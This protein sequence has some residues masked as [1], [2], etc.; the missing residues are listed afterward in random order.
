MEGSTGLWGD[1]FGGDGAGAG[2]AGAA[3]AAACMARGAGAASAAACCGI[4]GAAAAG[5]D[6]GGA[7]IF[8]LGA[9]VGLGG[10]VMRTVSFLGWTFEASAGFGGTAPGAGVGVFSDIGRSLAYEE[11]GMCQWVNP[12]GDLLAKENAATGRAR[13]PV[14]SLH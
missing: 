7:G 1:A 12:G 2:R 11:Q 10:K 4:G 5:S 6:C 14:R 13:K 3:G 8:M 9:A